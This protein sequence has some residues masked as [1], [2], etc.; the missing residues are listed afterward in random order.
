M[1]VILSRKGF[2]GSNGGIMSPIID[3]RVML[4]LPIPSRDDKNIPRGKMKDSVR[5]DELVCC[6]DSLDKILTELWGKKKEQPPEY[7]HLDPDIYKERRKTSVNGWC[8]TFGQIDQVAGYLD[9]RDVGEGDLFLFF[10]NFRNVVKDNGTYKYAKSDRN[11]KLDYY[12]RPI[13]VIWGYL[14]VERV[15]KNPSEIREKFGWHPHACEQRLNGINNRI[16]VAKNKLTFSDR[17][18]CGIFDY[19]EKFV[20]TMPG[21]P[22][23]TW[24]YEAAYD[25]K[26]LFKTERKNSAKNKEGIYYSGIWQELVLKEDDVT[27]KW[28]KGLFD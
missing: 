16:Y 10:G 15:V 20:L 24:K 13:Q 27:D 25:E 18:G 28:A 21:K 6:G 4:S 14:Q 5:Y 17:P 2:D 3:N 8:Q 9:G 12:G 11:N 1:K 23:A 26:H 22:K 19:N 7:C